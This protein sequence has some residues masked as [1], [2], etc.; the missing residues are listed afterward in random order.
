MRRRG[1]L[2][3]RGAMHAEPYDSIRCVICRSMRAGACGRR[4]DT[5][6]RI[7]RRRR[8]AGTSLRRSRKKRRPRAGACAKG[9][10]RF[11]KNRMARTH[12][13]RKHRL[14]SRKKERPQSHTAPRARITNY[15]VVGERPSRSLSKITIIGADAP[16]L[17]R[18]RRSAKT[19]RSYFTV[20]FPNMYIGP[21]SVHASF[22]R[23]DLYIQYL[24]RPFCRT[25]S[26][27]LVFAIISDRQRVV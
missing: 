2:C 18:I 8:A 22:L 16:C 26:A 15:E 20:P 1:R 17:Q 5:S 21:P 13:C 10:F 14:F 24:P 27:S 23:S 19:E 3:L 9:A 12:L 7:W 4:M 25:A 6:R 11:A